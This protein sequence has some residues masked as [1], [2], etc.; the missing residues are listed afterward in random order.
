MLKY[1]QK[2]LRGII[3]NN[4]TKLFKTSA[5]GFNRNDVINYIEKTKN[6]FYDYKLQTQRTIDDLNEKIKELETLLKEKNENELSV[7]STDAVDFSSSVSQINEAADH[8]RETA[9][10][11]CDDIG[12]FL[13]KIL[14]ADRDNYIEEILS[15]DET[16]TETEINN[17]TSEECDTDKSSDTET[18]G[19]LSQFSQIIDDAFVTD[20]KDEKN[21]DFSTEKSILDGLLGKSLY[22]E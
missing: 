7:C 9:D 20:K 18:F 15:T 4:V 17:E 10:K 6:D 5:F 3:M 13:D 11:I 22:S 14:V 8:L 19:F 12:E 16:E 2:R 21:D 1:Y